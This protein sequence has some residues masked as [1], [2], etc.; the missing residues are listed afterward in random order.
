MKACLLCFVVAAATWL[1][2]FATPAHAQTVDVAIALAADVSL[3]IDAE[4]FELQ[5]R[6]Y[7][8]AV[9]DRRFLEA[10]QAGQNGSVAL[11]FIEWAGE[12][13]Q[14]M[15]AKWT[16]IR[17]G[18]GTA[19]FAKTLRDAP[20]SFAGCT[21]IGAGIDFAVVRLETSGFTPKRRV[22][23]VSGDGIDNSGRPVSDARDVAVAKGIT[24]NGLAIINEKTG[25]IPGN[26]LYF[27][28]H[29]PGGL[30]MYY[31]DHVI[32]GP[33][34]FVLQIVNFDTVAEAMTNKLIIEVS[35]AA[36]RSKHAAAH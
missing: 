35:G 24:I 28:T 22:I 9:T 4:E 27:H 23:D 8:A 33:G 21:A 17:D 19:V 5:R 34:A 6:G 30:P 29:P 18:E 31:H 11:C 7:A 3:S 32:G 16:V 36:R 10:I 25:G 14:A 12:A 1:E 13:Q 20:R 2:I 26:Y 15:V